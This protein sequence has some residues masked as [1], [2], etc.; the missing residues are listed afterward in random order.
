MGSYWLETL[1]GADELSDGGVHHHLCHRQLFVL[2]E[3]VHMLPNHQAL[4]RVVSRK[5]TILS[6]Y[7]I[8]VIII[9]MY[10]DDDYYC[11]HCY[12]HYYCLF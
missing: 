9:T 4:L 8:D 10:Y 1:T 11:Y 5:N 6:L 2:G 7:I 12:Y 3:C